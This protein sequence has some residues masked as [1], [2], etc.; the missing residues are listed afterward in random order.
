MKLTGPT[1]TATGGPYFKAPT[2]L[3]SEFD[4]AFRELQ[5]GYINNIELFYSEEKMPHTSISRRSHSTRNSSK[6]L[7][8]PRIEEKI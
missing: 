4:R 5:Q 7:F 6:F 2:F 8:Y 3:F 1:S